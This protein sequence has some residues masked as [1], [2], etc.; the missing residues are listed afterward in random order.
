MNA[1]KIAYGK[2]HASTNLKAMLVNGTSFTG[3]LQEQQNAQTLLQQQH[4]ALKMT[5]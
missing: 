3:A 2:S 5:H 4:T 1:Q